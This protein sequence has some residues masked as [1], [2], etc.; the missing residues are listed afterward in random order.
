MSSNETN[1]ANKIVSER[2]TSINEAGKG[3]RR[4]FAIASVGKARWYWVVWPSLGELQTSEKPLFHIADGYEK[5][6]AEAVE[7]ALEVAGMYATWI[8][9]KY[10]SAYHHNTKAGIAPQGDDPRR[11]ESPILVVHEFLY[12]DV[13]N[14]ATRQWDSVPHRVVRSTGKY[15]YVEQRPYSPDNLTGSWLDSEVPTYR[16]DRQSLEREG[17]AFIP[18]TA[19]LADTEEPIFFGDERVKWQG[20]HLPNC[21]KVLQLTW[22]CTVMEVHEAYRRLVKSAHPDGGGN[23]DKFLELQ[24]AY[25]QALRICR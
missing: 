13:Y 1:P 8:A 20:E 3:N 6:K 14:A 5:T 16:L 18:A 19:S 7:K 17:Y 10:A 24:A 11:A 2:I 12:R 23:H 22:P 4:F 25:E 15:V 21:L 9:A